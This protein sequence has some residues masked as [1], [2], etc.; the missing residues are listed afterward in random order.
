M[1]VRL[2]SLVLFQSRVRYK[3]IFSVKASTE[4]TSMP[5]VHIAKYSYAGRALLAPHRVLSPR[6]YTAGCECY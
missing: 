2:K 4:V 6:T 5:R 3:V 1:L